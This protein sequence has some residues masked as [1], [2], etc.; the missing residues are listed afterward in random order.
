MFLRSFLQ[1]PRSP[2]S[3]KTQK[4][5]NRAWAGTNRDFWDETG[6]MAGT[7]QRRE[8]PLARALARPR[9]SVRA[10]LRDSLGL[11]GP[12]RAAATES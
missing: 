11:I 4:G 8:V 3:N 12:T 10:A 2:R 1:A 9:L 7:N 6:A 5:T